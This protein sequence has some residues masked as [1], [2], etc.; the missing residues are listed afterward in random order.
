[1]TDEPSLFLSDD[2]DFSVEAALGAQAQLPP[3]ESAPS[4]DASTRSMRPVGA[5][6]EIDGANR[7]LDAKS[8][9]RESS[10]LLLHQSHPRM[11]IKSKIQRRLALVSA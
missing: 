11:K 9:G 3:S 4:G 2:E 7:L 1:M 6:D 5:I 8:N 10:S